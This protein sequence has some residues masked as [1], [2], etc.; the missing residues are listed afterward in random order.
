MVDISSGSVP[1]E[2]GAQDD[3]SILQRLVTMFHELT[4]I[5]VV[6]AV[7]NVTIRLTDK[8]GRT[9]TEL[10]AGGEPITRAL[11]TIFDL[12]DGDVTNVISPEL[13][14]DEAIRTYHAQ[15]VQA[16]LAV[17][18]ANLKAVLEFGRALIDQIQ[19]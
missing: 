6:T 2:G 4:E 13:K 11:V 5:K 17:L 7:Q 18:P 19:R 10:D 9:K 14:D 16:S 12:I 3:R 15:Q 8:D 1:S